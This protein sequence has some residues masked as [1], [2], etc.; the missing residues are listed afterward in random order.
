MTDDSS[1]Q[2]RIDN[3]RQRFLDDLYRV[4]PEKPMGYLPVESIVRYAKADPDEVVQELQERGLTVVLF[5]QPHSHS[6]TLYA[7]DEAALRDLLEQPQHVQ[8]LQEAD[9]PTEPGAFVRKV[10]SDQAPMHTALF[11]LVADAFADPHNGLRTDPLPRPALTDKEAIL[12]AEKARDDVLAGIQLFHRD[13][14]DYVNAHL[15]GTMTV[16]E[17]I[18]FE[19][20]AVGVSSKAS[21]HIP[22]LDRPYGPVYGKGV[23]RHSIED[24]LPYATDWGEYST[25][26]INLK[27]QQANK[28][29]AEGRLD[30]EMPEIDGD[31][32]DRLLFEAATVSSQL[33]LGRLS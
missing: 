28:A 7:Y 1:V 17:L 3:A 19:V 11:D 33:G 5:Q 12:A 32:K 6:P 30:F 25:F 21:F 16:D 9:W 10:E 24:I 13:L 22:Y 31:I 27:L 29:L 20:R 18:A 8:T 15:Y 23:L 2:Q 26:D 4:G 14:P